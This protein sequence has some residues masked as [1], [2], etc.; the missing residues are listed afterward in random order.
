MSDIAKFQKMAAA[1]R[2]ARDW[3]QFHNPKDMALSLVLEAAEVME[4]FQWKTP[5]EVRAYLKEHKGEV[6]EELADVL[7][8]IV[9]MSHDMNIDLAKAFEAKMKKNEQ[10]YPVEKS[11]G[12]HTKYNKL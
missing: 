6:A 3:K 11:K 9:L 7:H 8:W 5:E 2:D 10:R 1:F 4:H 12:K